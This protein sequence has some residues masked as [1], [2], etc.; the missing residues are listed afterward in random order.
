MYLNCRSYHSLRYG[1]LSIKDLVKQAVA[2][3]SKSI[4]L[5][6]INTV[7]GIYEFA[8]TCR[9]NG[10]KPVVG[11]EMRE[12]GKLHFILLAKNTRGVGAICQLRT[13]YNMEE[14]PLPARCPALP[15]TAV[16]YPMSEAPSALNENEY[17]GVQPHEINLLIRTK[18]QR[19]L[20]KM[21]ICAPITLSDK[22]SYKLHCIL[23]AI[24][25][26]VLLS[27]LSREDC[28]R[29]DEHFRLIQDLH[30][31]FQDYPQI[32]ANTQQLLASCSFD[33]DYTTPKNKK[34]FTDSREGDRLL[35]AELTKKGLLRRYGTKHELAKQR[36]E[37]ELQV[38]D[39]LN[40]SGYFLI[41][42]DIVQYSN[43]QGFM[44][45]GRGSGA[46]SIIAY[47]LGITDICPL[48]LDLYFERFLNLNRKVPPDFD[49]D[50]G[51]Q[52]RDVILRYIFDRYGK[53]HVAFCGTNIEFKYRSI[54]RELGKVFGLPKEELDALATQPTDRHDT[55][56]VVRQ[57][58]HYGN[59]L[60]KYPNQRS[61]HACGILISEEPI[62]QSRHW[63][64][65]QK[66]SQLYSLICMWP[67]VL[68]WRNLISLVNAALA[69][70]TMP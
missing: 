61:M 51:W 23:R 2:S 15:D 45:I 59:L 31:I 17:I 6:D 70:S 66:A 25:R 12:N 35:L 1:T 4:A 7:S 60:E 62:T 50:W 64:Y 22:P 54:F 58:H 46:N 38:I 44:H 9:Q 43:N 49:I 14:T 65:P 63:N 56:S 68:D 29:P 5:T 16:I 8:Q 52:E 36:A 67:K 27:R 20:A 48:E 37:R 10:I 11:M 24:D 33:F 13:I 39:E 53:D 47:C 28:C 26:N 55:N 57:I 3:G 18:W 40:F 21:V 19:Y 32:V 30:A 42:W 41:T 69:V 34:H